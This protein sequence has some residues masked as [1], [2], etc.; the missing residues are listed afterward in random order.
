MV[1]PSKRAQK[2]EA[3]PA[4]K[5]IGHFQASVKKKWLGAREFVGDFQ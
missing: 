1:P 4:A 5:S 2:P 3:W